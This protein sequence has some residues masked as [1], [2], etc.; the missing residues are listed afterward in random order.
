VTF[1]LIWLLMYADSYSIYQNIAVLIV[2]LLV[3]GGINGVLWNRW[4]RHWE[5]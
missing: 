3:L 5:G 2:S 4:S 1:L